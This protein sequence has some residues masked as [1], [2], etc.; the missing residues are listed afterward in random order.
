MFEKCRIRDSE[1]TPARFCAPLAG[2]T[3]SAFRRLLSELG[4]CGAHWTE[5]LAARQ[6]LSEDFIK[7]PW[8]RRHSQEPFV[9]YQLMANP[10]DPLERI[11][12]HMAQHGV[13]AIDFNLA[14][15][16]LA[17]RSRGS[18]SALFENREGLRTVMNEARRH[19]PFILT[20]KIRFGAQQNNWEQRFM[21]RL[22]LLEDAGVDA[23]TVHPRFFGEKFKRRAR[24]ELIPWVSS[25]MR[26]PLIA[27]GDICR[28]EQVQEHSQHLRAAS[29]IMIGRMAVAQPWI[30]SHWMEASTVNYLDI[31]RKMHH[32]LANDF[33]FPTALRRLQMFSKYFAKNFVFGHHFNVSIGNARTM[34]EALERGEEFLSGNPAILAQP[35][36]AGV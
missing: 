17:A 28:S 32:Y 13:K 29:A 11:L 10:K 5:M 7:S 2:Y 3:H 16:A 27:N 35:D 12:N 25:L 30:F 34:D 6:I 26:V 1:F 22:H 20:A 33:S 31:W 4:G 9:F 21:D 36:V 15:D 24:L 14:C 23:I 18:G 8:L 19:W